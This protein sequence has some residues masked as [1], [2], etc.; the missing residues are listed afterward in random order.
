[1]LAA[2]IEKHRQIYSGKKHLSQF[3]TVA[4]LMPKAANTHTEYVI[5]L[6]HCNN[7]CMNVPQVYVICT[8]PASE[9]SFVVSF[10][11]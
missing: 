7:V 10:K 5:L 8:L 2:H 3:H 11:A 6:F 4:N 1:M 9:L